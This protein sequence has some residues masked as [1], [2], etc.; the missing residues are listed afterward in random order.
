MKSHQYHLPLTRVPNSVKLPTDKVGQHNETENK[1]PAVDA[2]LA[3][4]PVLELA[5]MTT[6]GTCPARYDTH[7]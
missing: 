3:G 7:D 4:N 2:D 1:I 6:W 5:G